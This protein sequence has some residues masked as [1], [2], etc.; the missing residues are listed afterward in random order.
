M[1]RRKA[2]EELAYTRTKRRVA[3]IRRQIEQIGYD[4][5]DSEIHAVSAE[6]DTLMQALDDFQLTAAECF[7]DWKD[8]RE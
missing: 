6:A 7:T 5:F 4:W 8:E 1:T 2:F 3:V